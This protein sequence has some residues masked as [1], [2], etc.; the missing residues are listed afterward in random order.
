MQSYRVFVS[1]SHED[2][3]LAKA[4]V[5][6][7]KRNGLTPLWDENLTG[8]RGFDAQIKAFIAYA[9]VFLPLITPSSTARG[10]V[11]Q[12]IGYAMALRVPVLPVCRERF[13]GEML[14]MLHAVRLGD[15]SAT[16]GGN[17][18]RHV[19]EDLI[20][21]AAA[22]SRPDENEN[23]HTNLSC[24]RSRRHVRNQRRGAIVI[25]STFHERS[26]EN[27]S[28]DPVLRSRQRGIPIRWFGGVG[29]RWG[30]RSTTPGLP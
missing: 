20:R 11:H 12:E 2:C 14:Q 13:P 15:D 5:Q 27:P 10:W 18:S 16:F 3:D 23:I 19:F 25:R 30:G 7:L 28:R 6:V 21:R 29:H 4:V 17:L 22:D 9:H 24:G 8:G 1:Y 26:E